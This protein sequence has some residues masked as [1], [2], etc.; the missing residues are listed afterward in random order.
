MTKI[1]VKEADLFKHKARC[2][3]ILCREEKKPSGILPRL[4][5]K[6]SGA[7]SSSYKEK[8]FEGKLNQKLWLNAG[9]GVK[10]ENI[11]LIGVGK[12]GDITEDRLR[13]AGGSAAKHA[14]KN[15]CESIAM[16]LPDWEIKLPKGF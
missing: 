16:A 8:R 1:T 3:V 13:Q 9:G 5:K 11:L 14:E 15:K 2:M 10:A 7:I 12:A 6:L 4:D